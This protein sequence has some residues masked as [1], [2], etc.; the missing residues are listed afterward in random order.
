MRRLILTL[1]ATFNLANVLFAV[2]LQYFSI[3]TNQAAEVKQTLDA[4]E[5]GKLTLQDLNEKAGTEGCRKL[6]GYY[7]S[8]TNEITVKAKLPV[9]RSLNGFNLFPEATNLGAQYVAVFSNDWHGWR[10]LGAAYNS[11]NLSNESI[12]AYSNAVKLG[13][14]DS[15]T[16]LAQVALKNNRFDLIQ[17][18][19]PQLFAL[20]DNPQTPEKNKLN[21]I[22]TLIF[23]SVKAHQKDIFIKTLEGE[24]LKQIL[25]NWMVKNNVMAGCKV[26]KGEDM[27]KIRQAVEAANTSETKPPQ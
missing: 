12:H 23:Y 27:D 17:D 8:H 11:L 26:F 22:S 1:L 5:N 24:D 6:V 3:T 9:G 4:Y 7:L 16:S 14:K 10:L 20:K 2:D 21:L 25:Q 13:D 15:Y 19:L 18:M